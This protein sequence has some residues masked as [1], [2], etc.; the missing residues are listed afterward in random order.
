MPWYL[1]MYGGAAVFALVMY[2]KPDRSV[3]TWAAPEAEKRLDEAGI[4]WRYKPSPH[5]GFPMGI[6]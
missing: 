2:F 5:S 4:E 6:P 3:R 1:G